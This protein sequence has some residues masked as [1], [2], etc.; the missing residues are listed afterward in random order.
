M[1]LYCTLIIL[2]LYLSLFSI[3]FVV[4]ENGTGD[5]LTIQ[6]AL[7]NS[8]SGAEIIVKVGNYDY[9][10]INS[11]NNLTE[12]LYIHSEFDINDPTN[13]YNIENTFI[14]AGTYQNAIEIINCETGE[15]QIIIEGFSI[16]NGHP[17]DLNDGHGIYSFNN[18]YPSLNIILNYNYIY[19]NTSNSYGGGV[20]IE[21]ASSEIYNCKIYNN[22]S[23]FSGSGMYINNGY[24][25]IDNC[26]INDNDSED[27]GGGV[28]F[29]IARG[30]IQNNS[31]FSNSSQYDSGGIGC[32]GGDNQRFEVNIIGNE[33]YNNVSHRGG[34]IGITANQYHYLIEENYIHDN[35]VNDRV[36]NNE[37][38]PASGGGIRS[39]GKTTI[40][41]NEILNNTSESYGGGITYSNYYED[42]SLIKDCL[43][44]YNT[45]DC[46]GG[47]VGGYSSIELVNCTI[48][49]NSTDVAGGGLWFD[50]YYDSTSYPMDIDIN[51]CIIYG[52]TA[53]NYPQQIHISLDQILINEIDINYSCLQ[54]G[55]NGIA[56]SSNIVNSEFLLTQNPLFQINEYT[57]TI[58]SPCIDAGDP[59][60]PF[61]QDITVSDMGCYYF[62]HDY[63]IHRFDEG[64]A[65]T[66][67]PRLENNIE[68][69]P[70]V[71]NDID[72]FDGITGINVYHLDDNEDHPVVFWNG[73]QWS[74]DYPA[75]SHLLYKI[76]IQPEDERILIVDGDR[77]PIDYT[78]EDFA[79]ME[80]GDYY[81]LGYWIPYPQSMKD[82]FGD[83]TDNDFWQYVEKVKSE[84][85]FYSP[86]NNQRGDDTKIPIAT[87]PDYLR[88]EYGKGYMVMFNDTVEDFQW[89][90]SLE[91]STPRDKIKSE[92]F[93]Y[94]ETPDYEAIDFVDVPSTVTEIGVFQ[95]ETCVGAVTVE[96]SCAQV[97]VYPEDTSRS[98]GYYTF[99]IVEERG[100][101]KPL[102]D[103]YIFDKYSG[104]FEQS[105]IIPGNQEYS[106]VRFGNNSSQE[107]AP[108]LNNITL[109]NNY[110]NPFNPH[111]TIEFSLAKAVE[112][113]ELS[114]YNLKGQKVTTLYSGSS[115][116]GNFQF[117]W[118]G[119]DKNGNTVSSG[120]YMYKLKTGSKEITRKML[121]MK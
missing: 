108:E 87:S 45:A 105:L 67:F 77:L 49:N 21:K 43:I 13:T 118:K 91:I 73:Y 23:V 25:I 68:D 79:P 106:L 38:I 89:N 29:D 24:C 78:L 19:S 75:M 36:E 60:L 15:F 80:P 55:I 10:I 120:L 104:K 115:P 34:G 121:L 28:F 101:S 64:I 111:T 86:A 1:R 30:N 20:Y 4:D 71:L 11:L 37:V 99:E 58:N 48:C 100:S 107:D 76:K 94:S 22:S 17:V 47:Y 40:S 14:D 65:W 54:N 2:S 59:T 113:V 88:L 93:T 72:P 62:H 63:D 35:T 27:K 31:I 103:Y 33:I 109:S 82:A 61:D 112:H 81:W 53:Q 41:N 56:G 114:I 116:S 5:F 83:G 69:L 84:D 9:I 50:R 46:G 12:N 7:D 98:S 95:D 52:N 102:K 74:I 39:N 96:D 16:I 44:A 97:L 119:E 51:N 18:S 6:D 8:N 26:I 117:T 110:P 66:S 85:W 32:V 92:S 90:N 3:V 57:L 70:T 42:V